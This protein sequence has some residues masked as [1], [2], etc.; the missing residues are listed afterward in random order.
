[1][2]HHVDDGMLLTLSHAGDGIAFV[3]LVVAS[4]MTMPHSLIC[5]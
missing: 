1:M 5:V 3:M 4:P 2:P